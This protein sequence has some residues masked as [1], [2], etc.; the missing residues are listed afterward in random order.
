MGASSAEYEQQIADVRG[1]IESKIVELRERSRDT[2]RRSRRVL[3][4]A[5]GTGAAVGAAAVTAL[6]IY[7]M[8]RPATLAERVERG[9]PE[10][11]W[12][13]VRNAR[14]KI[15]LG[16]RRALPPVRLYV[17]DQQVG[18]QPPST[19]VEKVAIRAAQAVGTA[20][21]AAIVGRLTDQFRKRGGKAA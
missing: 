19:T 11:W 7:R 6:F 8:T 15:E 18:E 9:L 14:D 10:G 2:I 5:V 20:M 13:Y 3:I 12:N 17:G 21:A 1:S 16:W 4:I